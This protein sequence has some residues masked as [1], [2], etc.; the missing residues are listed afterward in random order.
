[1]SV[2]SSWFSPPL[3]HRRSR[4]TSDHTLTLHFHLALPLKPRSHCASI[5]IIIKVPIAVNAYVTHSARNSTL[6]SPTESHHR[7]TFVPQAAVP[8]CKWH[9]PHPVGLDSTHAQTS[10][11][12]AL[13]CSYS[14]RRGHDFQEVCLLGICFF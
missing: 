4:V 5:I 14:T 7:L 11:P 12:F 1:M 9:S 10:F 2:S 8:Q 13:S 3:L 6:K